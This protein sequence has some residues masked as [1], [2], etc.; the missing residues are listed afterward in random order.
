MP[1]SFLGF[2][3]PS[4]HLSHRD[5]SGFHSL[6]S[7]WIQ[8]SL[9]WSWY[10]SGLRR[11]AAL[12]E[13]RFIQTSWTAIHSLIWLRTRWYVFKKTMFM[14]G[15]SSQRSLSG[16]GG[17][18]QILFQ[19]EGRNLPLAQGTKHQVRAWMV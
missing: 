17:I 3:F 5:L 12:L 2:C 13:A 18:S 10:D 15:Q 16:G 1:W 4:G 14:K 9:G 7:V 19:E 6:H 11:L 8:G